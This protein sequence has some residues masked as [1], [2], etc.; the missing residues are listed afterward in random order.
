ML[1][2]HK[3][4][5]YTCPS[6]KWDP[7][8][9]KYDDQKRAPRGAPLSKELLEA[10]IKI[11][12]E[13][14]EITDE[15]DPEKI[16]V[17]CPNWEKHTSDTG[18]KQTI[19]FTGA[20]GSRPNFH[21]PHFHCK[22]I[23]LDRGESQRLWDA[24]LE[25]E[26]IQL[27]GTTQDEEGRKRLIAKFKESGSFYRRSISYPHTMVY[28]EKGM[29]D[30]IEIGV[31]N[32]PIVCARAGIRFSRALKKCKKEVIPTERE[33]RTMLS[34]PEIEEL[35]IVKSYAHRPLLCRRKTGEPEIL[36]QQYVPELEV[37]VLS[38]PESAKELSMP[39]KEAK[40]LLDQLLDYWTFKTPAD[41]SRGLSE[42]FTPALLQG[43]FI[44]R[45]LPVFLVVSDQPV[46]GKTLWQHTCSNIYQEKSV[47]KASGGL[48]GGT[49]DMIRAS[50]KAG[51]TFCFVDEVKNHVVSPL[52]NAIVTGQNE[53]DIRSA[54][55]KAIRASIDH[56][57]IQMAG[58]QKD[59][60]LEEQLS[61]RIIPIQILLK[62]PYRKAPDKSLLEDWI[63]KHSLKYLGA[64]YSIIIEW[65]KK[66]EP[67][68]DDNTR[69]PAWTMTVNGIMEHVLGMEPITSGLKK[70]QNDAANLDAHWL[71]LIIPVLKEEELE[72]KG[73]EKEIA[74]ML[75]PTALRELFLSAGL[76]IPGNYSINSADAGRHQ[77]A[78]ISQ[79]I[80]RL[81]IHK[82][83]P[84]FQ[85][86]ALGDHFVHCY[87][88]GKNEKGKPI[89]EYIF[90]NTDFIPKLR[91]HYD[92]NEVT[93]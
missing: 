64:V 72:W 45:P 51:D 34:I 56:L 4:E 69:L 6:A 26:T 38:K 39:F 19:C 14:Y 11:I 62:L 37:I 82:E 29:K 88:C 47:I 9:K 43:G 16:G 50:I 59:F 40:E 58:N 32:F 61:T 48:V 75:S 10:R 44:K 93:L 83:S 71:E 86:R 22:S 1:S 13:L 53:A 73:E 78:I 15:S 66:G 49:D 70:V 79:A 90:S 7:W 87:Q 60:T 55:E 77:R 2:F 54:H 33:I 12:G 24:L 52:L 25:A 3:W 17:V 80:R 76:G 30:P 23:E 20:D 63:P 31:D 18:D 42:L 35:P 5:K 85:I 84:V 46:A 67:P 57:I 8:P 89:Y 91:K 27:Y 74:W 41:R 28:W 65:M 81:R 21:C 92:P 68:G 36:V